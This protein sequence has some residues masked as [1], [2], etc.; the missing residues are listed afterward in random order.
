MNILILGGTQACGPGLPT[1]KSYVAQFVR[2]LKSG[3][4]PIQI[5]QR[6]VS[7]AEAVL[8][9]P[10][11]RLAEYDLILLQFDAP[12][13]GLPAKPVSRLIRQ[14]LFWLKG[15][16]M[17]QLDT[18]REQLIK[19]LLQVR[20]HSRQVVLMSPLPHVGRL[21]QQLLQCIQTI[22]VQE[23][24]QWQVPLF[25]VGDHLPGG[26]ELFQDGSVDQL[27]AVAHELLGSELHTF[28]T[29]PSY[30]LWS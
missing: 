7:L 13:D 30:T 14:G 29:E 6:S 18:L 26:D 5:D 9:L 16:R 12:F 8:L 17:A 20:V 2:R 4:H 1:G 3:R 22:Y 25:S 21:E 19:V 11:L 15:Y 28:I 23:S 27:N 10:Q 24:R